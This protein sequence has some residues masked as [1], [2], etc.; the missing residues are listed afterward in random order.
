MLFV[1]KALIRIIFLVG[2]VGLFGLVGCGESSLPT[3]SLVP[4]AASN[5]RLSSAVLGEADNEFAATGAEC[6]IDRRQVATMVYLPLG[7]DLGEGIL[8]CVRLRAPARVRDSDLHS[9]LWSITRALIPDAD[10]LRIERFIVA[11]D[12]RTDTLAFVASLDD[13]GQG[14]EYGINL[15]DLNL[16]DRTVFEELLS[17]IVHEY[18]HILTLNET[19]VDYDAVLLA[20]YTDME[21]SDA[22]YDALVEQVE[23]DCSQAIG[24]FDGE[25]CFRPGSHLYAFHRVFW[26]GYGENALER[27]FD[28]SLFS[29]HGLDFVN[30]YAATSPTEDF[31][32]SFSAW[33]L[34]EHEAFMI[35]EQVEAKFDFFEGRPDLVAVRD[36]IAAG[37]DQ[38][39]GERLF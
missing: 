1:S 3:I 35:T 15:V 22:E 27:G 14:W 11:Q 36:Q 39:R 23:A 17:T 19:Q 2:A 37:I 6:G 32:E 10:E 28:G 31:A 7:E 4:S 29:D 16:I 24:I 13:T 8:G 26:D 5:P 25:V 18:A 30:D 20:A 33:L 38:V 9:R 34:R 12:G 21:M